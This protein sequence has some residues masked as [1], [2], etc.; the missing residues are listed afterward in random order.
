[1][2]ILAIQ[3]KQTGDVLLT[4]PAVRALKNKWPAAEIHYLTQA[5]ND[6]I[7]LRSNLVT[8][9]WCCAASAGWR[10]TWHLVASLRK[11]KFDLVV[12]FMSS[13]RT[14]LITLLSAAKTRI[15]FKIN[16]RQFA[17]NLKISPPQD[18][19]YSAKHKL[20]MLKP[21]GI[22][23][24]DLQLEFQ[25]EKTNPKLPPQPSIPLHIS[26][27]PLSR[28]RYKL[29]PS[30]N[31]IFLLNKLGDKFKVKLSIIGSQPEFQQLQEI[32]KGIKLQDALRIKDFESWSEV[33]NFLNTVDFH[34]GNDNGQR[35]FVIAKGIP[36]FAIFGQGH[37]SSWTPPQS[38]HNHTIENQIP[39]KFHCY[40]PQCRLACIRDI[41]PQLVWGKLQ[42]V[43]KSLFPKH[44]KGNIV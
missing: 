12:D 23:S 36:N 8:K 29:W 9:I 30:D 13:P 39:C 17:Y 27:A 35:H 38:G 3:L 14:A 7:F 21:L 32:A 15:G 4:T 33:W 40:Y 1:M 34:I 11:E 18:K 19:D 5:P 6:E 41:S 24:D 31:F 37:P 44:Y 43:L 28:R 22:I 20:Q 10:E 42:V 26:I 2:K 25:S 16:Q